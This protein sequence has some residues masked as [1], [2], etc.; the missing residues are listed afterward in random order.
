MKL[1]IVTQVIDDKD[2]N[3]GFFHRWVMEFAK[4]SSLVHVI[5]L[6]EG[7]HAFPENVYVHSLGKDKG[8]GFFSYILNF[9]RFA[10]GLRKEYDAVFI[11]MNSEYLLLGGLLWRALGKRTLLWH[12][13]KSMTWVHRIGEKLVD[14]IATASPESY[15]LK[16]RKVRVL[17]HGIDTD[18]FR[19]TERTKE[20]VFRII[21]TGRIARVKGL[22][23]LLR[24]TK[25]LVNA[26]MKIELLILGGPLTDED[27]RYQD[28]I[29]KLTQELSV[30]ESVH[31]VGAV[32][33]QD[34]IPY[35]QQADVF[36][37]CSQTGSLDKAVLEAMAVGLPVITSNDGLR[38]TLAHHADTL[39]FPHGDV[40][41]LAQR[42]RG[43]HNLPISERTE[44]S[45]AL[46]TIVETDHGL[47]NFVP[48]MVELMHQ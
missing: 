1:L 40:T 46:R 10:W 24:S 45:L 18:E 44:L 25:E 47:K 48:R 4:H 31:F 19:P 20:D 36:V 8:K 39:M 27:A 16:S 29:Q 14:V 34:I 37:N 6:R 35:L 28:E 38:S 3:L 26:G 33:H 17:G 21:S 5:C 12:T 22:G 42:L 9:Y 43:I 11:H 7:Q 23:T 15:R 32:S 41:A 2:P 13:H 30:S